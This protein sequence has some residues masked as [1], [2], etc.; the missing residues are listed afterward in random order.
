MVGRI[1]TAGE[2]YDGIANSFLRLGVFPRARLDLE[3]QLA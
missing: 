2:I 1:T 3:A